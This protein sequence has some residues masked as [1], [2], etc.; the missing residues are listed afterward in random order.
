LPWHDIANTWNVAND[1]GQSSAFQ[2]FWWAELASIFVLIALTVALLRERRW[3][4]A[5]YV[6]L[7]TLILTSTTYSAAGAR[8]LMVAFP[9]YLWISRHRRAGYVYAL[10]AA[11]LMAVFVI[12]FTQGSWVD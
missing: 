12:A 9:L 6:G 11:P 2:V 1:S 5:T 3:G 8:A 7:V 4:E 10:L